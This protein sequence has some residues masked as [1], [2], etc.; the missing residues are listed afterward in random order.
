MRVEKKVEQSVVLVVDQWNLEDF[1][2]FLPYSC[3]DKILA[4]IKEARDQDQKIDRIEI[5]LS[6]ATLYGIPLKVV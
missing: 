1:N 6:G 2:L 5:K 4:A 3:P